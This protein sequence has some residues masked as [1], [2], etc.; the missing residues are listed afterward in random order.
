MDI[1]GGG[2]RR[3]RGTEA[4]VFNF[5]SDL[6]LMLIKKALVVGVILQYN[7][8]SFHFNGPPAS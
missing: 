4:C 2:G 5:W 1:W 7:I 3:E 6:C 8:Q